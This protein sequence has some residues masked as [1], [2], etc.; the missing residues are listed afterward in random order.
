MELH[1]TIEKFI[2]KRGFEVE[3]LIKYNKEDL[4]NPEF[5][6]NIGLSLIHI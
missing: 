2:K 1:P 6:P 4:P 5:I 3:D